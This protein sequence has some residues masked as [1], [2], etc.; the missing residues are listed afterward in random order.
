MIRRVKEHAYVIIACCMASSIFVLK[1]GAQVIHN[2]SEWT[3]PLA[4]FG[5]GYGDGV[6]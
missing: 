3:S 5:A 1:Y 6:R 4:L 2:A